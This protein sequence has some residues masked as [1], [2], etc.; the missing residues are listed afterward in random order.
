MVE[1]S[2][3]NTKFASFG[4]EKENPRKKPGG[5]GHLNYNSNEALVEW[6]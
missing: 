5:L 2:T 1:N 6:F 4:V 3:E